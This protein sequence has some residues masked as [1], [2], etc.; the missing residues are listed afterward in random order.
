MD[1]KRRKT[2]RRILQNGENKTANLQNGD[3]TKRRNYK[4]ANV[5]KRRIYKTANITKRRILQNGE[6]Y[7][8]ANREKNGEYHL[9]YIEIEESYK[10][11]NITKWRILQKGKSTKRRILQNDEYYKTANTTK[12]RNFNA[13]AGGQGGAEFCFQSSPTNRFKDRSCNI[14]S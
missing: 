14:F 9:E 12:R 7:K 13:Y 11:A 4:T 8:T 6:S 3:I 10:T 5:T 2:K 1:T